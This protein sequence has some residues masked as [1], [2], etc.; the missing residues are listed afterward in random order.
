MRKGKETTFRCCWR[1]GDAAPAAAAVAALES[2]S[3]QRTQRETTMYT[4][5][6]VRECEIAKYIKIP[7]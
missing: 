4:E 1:M 3:K 2:W 7:T 6:K 5:R